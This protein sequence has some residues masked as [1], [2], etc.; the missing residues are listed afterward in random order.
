MRESRHRSW[1]P[2]LAVLALISKYGACSAVSRRL[3]QWQLLLLVWAVGAFPVRRSATRG[4][5]NKKEVFP[6]QQV[7]RR[8]NMS[9]YHSPEFRWK[10]P[11][12]F[13]DTQWLNF[14]STN[15]HRQESKG[16]T[17]W[18]LIDLPALHTPVLQEKSIPVS[19]QGTFNS[20]PAH[21]SSLQ[22]LSAP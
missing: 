5:E 3:L 21:R 8:K 22:V 4:S 9:A 19:L 15:R 6:P 13:P 16:E 17:G 14:Q 18:L 1:A 7:F 20:L 12:K 2:L 11:R 10:L